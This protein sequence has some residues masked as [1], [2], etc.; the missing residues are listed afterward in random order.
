MKRAAIVILLLAATARADW[1]HDLSNDLANVGQ[2]LAI[3]TNLLHGV[4]ERCEATFY[5][6]EMDGDITNRLYLVAPIELVQAWTNFDYNS[7]TSA[8]VEGITNYYP[9]ATNA[10]GTNSLQTWELVNAMA[11]KTI[12]L[13]PFYVC[14][15]SDVSA[16]VLASNGVPMWGASNLL[17]YTGSTN[18]FGAG[19]P[20]QADRDTTFALG[21]LY[22]ERTRRFVYSSSGQPTITGIYARTGYAEWTGPGV[23]WSGS[24]RYVIGETTA[25]PM[26]QASTYGRFPAQ[27]VW[28]G[29]DFPAN[30]TGRLST[31][32]NVDA[33]AAYLDQGQ[34]LGDDVDLSSPLPHGEILIFTNVPRVVAVGDGLTTGALSGVSVTIQG[35]AGNVTSNGFY[36]HTAGQSETVALSGLTSQCASIW[37][38]VTNMVLVGD[39]PASLHAVRIETHGRHYM[40][41]TP[42]RQVYRETLVAIYK[43]LRE[44]KE[45]APYPYFWTEATWTTSRTVSVVSPVDCYASETLTTNFFG[46]TVREGFERHS[47]SHRAAFYVNNGDGSYT[48]ADYYGT[49]EDDE[50]YRGPD[51]AVVSDRLQYLDGRRWRFASSNSTNPPATVGAWRYEEGAPVSSLTTNNV[52]LALFALVPRPAVPAN[53]QEPDS[54]PNVWTP[55]CLEDPIDAGGYFDEWGTADGYLEYFEANILTIR[56]AFDNPAR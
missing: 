10:G 15:T 42:A 54:G 18:A 46:L 30:P 13:A 2:E 51:A 3:L 14:T 41:G 43:C 38:D 4:N 29:L 39:I 52:R 20:R 5:G 44:M 28:A 16:S 56:W 48:R 23:I 33:F 7:L 24:T 34:L 11:G 26:A 1:H 55:E 12:D 36:T 21:Q 40:P 47:E 19:L 32:T 31:V 49:Y 9:A 53:D 6:V 27:G 50:D 17:A 22:I 25:A 35:E 37:H 45:T 8:V